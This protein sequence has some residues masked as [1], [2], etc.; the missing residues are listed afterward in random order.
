MKDGMK[1]Y[2]HHAKNKIAD[3]NTLEGVNVLLTTY[4]TV[5]AEWSPGNLA[6]SSILFRVRWKRIVLDEG[7]Y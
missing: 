6:D 7:K 2:R 3:M 1:C 4:Q 5:S